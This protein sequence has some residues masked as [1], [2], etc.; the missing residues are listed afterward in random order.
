MQKQIVDELESIVRCGYSFPVVFQD[1]LELMVCALIRDDE[2][3]LEVMGRYKNDDKEIGS[4]PADFF[5]NAFHAL[6]D[7]M[8]KEFHD[9][10]GEIFQEHVTRGENGQFFTPDSA[11]KIMVEIV[12]PDIKEGQSIMDPSCGSGRTLLAATFKERKAIFYGVDIDIRCVHMT[13]LNL[14]FRNVNAAIV[15]GNTL[16]LDVWGGY[17]CNGTVFGGELVRM[18]EDDAKRILIHLQEDRDNNEGSGEDEGTDQ[19]D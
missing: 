5:K 2:R 13:T 6:M 9:Y 8:S 15:W 17:K 7:A 18:D 4:R 19:N 10:L 11:C 3:Y 16:T 1:W 14:L 12:A